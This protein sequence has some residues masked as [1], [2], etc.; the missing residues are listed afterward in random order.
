MTQSHPEGVGA[1]NRFS[2]SESE[3]RL[4]MFFIPSPNSHTKYLVHFY[5]GNI[6]MKWIRLP[7]HVVPTVLR[8]RQHDPIIFTFFPQT[9]GF[10]KC[11]MGVLA[12]EVI[13]FNNSKC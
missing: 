8:A 6:L 9:F 12:W 11:I 1:V 7:G 5:L 13:I 2:R 10:S 4:E 3:V